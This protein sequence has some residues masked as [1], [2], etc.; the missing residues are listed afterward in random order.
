VL[1]FA[2]ALTGFLIGIAA[3]EM[4]KRIGNRMV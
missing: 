3:Q 2:G 1:L 4:I